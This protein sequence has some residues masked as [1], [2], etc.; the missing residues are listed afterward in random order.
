MTSLI[1]DCCIT[2]ASAAAISCLPDRLFTEP[3]TPSPPLSLS[4]FVLM[5]SCEC[6]LTEN[7]IFFQYCQHITDS[8]TCQL[9][10]FSDLLHQ[11][12]F[13]YIIRIFGICGSIWPF[14]TCKRIC[15]KR[16]FCIKCTF[17]CVYHIRVNGMTHL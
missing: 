4:V 6:T 11:M 10:V 12:D 13:S 14:F 8:I 9:N 15:F 5:D 2:M 17:S 3:P 16:K 7:S 1:P